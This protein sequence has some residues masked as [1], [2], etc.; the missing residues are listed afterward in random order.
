MR[1]VGDIVK[2]RWPWLS[3]GLCLL[4][5][6]TLGLYWLTPKHSSVSIP[7]FYFTFGL[8][9]VS[10]ILYFRAKRKRNYWDFDTLFI[11]V[12]CL[13]GFST[14]FFY[15]DNLLYRSLF[16]SF[17]FDD[18]Y[19]NK[20]NLLFLIGMQSY[21][22]GS[23]V[24]IKE[25]K[26][27]AAKPRIINTQFLGIAILFLCVLFVITGGLSYFQSEYMRSS[28]TAGKGISVH[29]LVLLLSTAIAV[30]ATEFFNRR[31]N[32]T[33]RINKV[34]ILSVVVMCSMLLYVGNR[35]AASQL[36][37]PILGLYTLLLRNI[38]FRQTVIFMCIGIFSM[39]LIQNFRSGQEVDFEGNY[40]QIISDMTIPARQTYVAM[41]Y[42][43]RF[44]Y[45]Y[46]QTMA[47]GI[48]GTIPFAPSIL[49]EIVNLDG[50]AETLTKYT[51]VDYPLPE[52]LKIGLGTTV[53]GDIYLSFGWLG[54]VILMFYLG[55]FV[56]KYTCRSLQ[57]DYYA[58]IIMA[59]LLANSVFLARGSYTHAVRMIVWA[60]LI[61]YINKSMVLWRKS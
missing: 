44:G 22:V 28:T 8:L 54:V 13:I 19:V 7:L 35:T 10:L 34:V 52:H 3:M 39:W 29:V 53:I 60:L 61:A 12:C 1:F 36:I 5:A 16:L 6:C 59:G 50:S 26:K 27:M 56:N 46:G 31:I 4:F 11:T 24:R 18:S 15:G 33:Y 2:N 25:N 14:T 41:E 37:L 42:A 58:I 45:S 38:T 17:P 9:L 43:D 20:G 23:L 57:L 51:Y 40:V 47:M 32:P 49:G 21:F 48:V 30:V 55:R